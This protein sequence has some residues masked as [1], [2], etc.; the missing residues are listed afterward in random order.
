MSV[1]ST[2]RR[3]RRVSDAAIE[4]AA[5]SDPDTFMPDAEWF[6]RAPRRSPNQEDDNAA[7][8]SRCAGLVPET[9]QRLS[10][11]H[12]CRVARVHRG[13]RPRTLSDCV[14]AAH[15]HTNLF[16]FGNPRGAMRPK[17][18][19][20]PFQVERSVSVRVRSPLFQLR[21]LAPLRN[22]PLS[23]CSSPPSHQ[24]TQLHEDHA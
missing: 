16:S 14:V 8:R 9:R 4:R 15:R 1:T 24:L 12:Q 22:L 10:N 17:P 21:P 23:N 20:V 7:A 11:A 3:V 19:R 13:A 18:A 2:S 5:A 6:K